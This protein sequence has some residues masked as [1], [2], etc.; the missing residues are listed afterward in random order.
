M[1]KAQRRPW[2]DAE[3]VDAEIIEPK[4]IPETP[5]EEISPQEIPEWAKDT[6]LTEDAH[7]NISSK[8]FADLSSD[9]PSQEA[10]D[11]QESIKN[12]SD[13]TGTDYEKAQRL[14]V[15][16]E[17]FITYAA[18][19]GLPGDVVHTLLRSLVKSFE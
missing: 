14:N 19:K 11:L 5:A 6:F 1:K 12:L 9:A 17:H 13:T 2:S 16:S 8:L 7:K 18:S 4:K 3:I 10:K 15:M